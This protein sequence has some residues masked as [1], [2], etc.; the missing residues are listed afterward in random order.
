MMMMIQTLV[1]I[2]VFIQ[3]HI[4]QQGPG[5]QPED[6]HTEAPD[7]VPQVPSGSSVFPWLWVPG[8][9]GPKTNREWKTSHLSAHVSR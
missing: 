5:V 2:H 6:Q 3:T 7:Q 8:V 4:V 9:L 1:F